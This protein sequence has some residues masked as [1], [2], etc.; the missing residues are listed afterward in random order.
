[1][2]HRTVSDLLGIELVFQYIKTIAI[3]HINDITVK[4]NPVPKVKDTVDEDA[5]K[6]EAKNVD[7]V[8]RQAP[9]NPY[10]Y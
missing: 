9:Y 2:Y 8:V 1:M 10:P 5:S 6:V 7:E 4:A 3:V